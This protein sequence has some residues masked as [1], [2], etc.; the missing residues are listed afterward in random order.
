MAGKPC[1]GLSQQRM[2][3]YTMHVKDSDVMAGCGLAPICSALHLSA[4]TRLITSDA[5]SLLRAAVHHNL[6][7]TSSLSKEKH[8][9]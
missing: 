7:H 5:L 6:I 1:I 8:S 3:K 2:Y 9:D 4:H